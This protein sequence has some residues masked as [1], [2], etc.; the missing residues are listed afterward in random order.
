MFCKK[1]NLDY[2]FL[3]ESPNNEFTLPHLKFKAYTMNW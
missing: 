2:I 3:L 1:V